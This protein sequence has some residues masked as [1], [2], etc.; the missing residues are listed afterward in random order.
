MGIGNKKAEPR[1]MINTAG[2]ERAG[3]VCSGI[4]PYIRHIVSYQIRYHKTRTKQ[5]G[6]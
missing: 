5:M 4:V 1:T 2:T 6:Y 3:M